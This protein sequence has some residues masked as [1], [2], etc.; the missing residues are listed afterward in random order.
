MSEK[1]K[2]VLF[3][4]TL[5]SFWGLSLHSAA[6]PKL[7][8]EYDED[9][10]SEAGCLWDD[11]NKSCGMNPSYRPTITPHRKEITP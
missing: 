6:M 4:M 8:S 7:C 3:G 1:T 5:I 10:C 9:F 11:K 2:K